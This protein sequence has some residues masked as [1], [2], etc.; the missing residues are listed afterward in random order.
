MVGSVV[1]HL[2][3]GMAFKDIEEDIAEE[4][5]RL[6]LASLDFPFQETDRWCSWGCEPTGT[7][8][9]RERR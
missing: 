5:L 9:S 8:M 2:H 6:H 4:T 3:I 7:W 1:G